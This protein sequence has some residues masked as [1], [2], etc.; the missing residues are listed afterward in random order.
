[1]FRSLPLVL[2]LCWC[3]AGRLSAQT[4]FACEGQFYLTLTDNGSTNLYLVEV[5]ALTGT[6]EF[7][8]I[9]WLGE[10]VNATGYRKT[11]NLIYGLQPLD[12][13]LFRIDALG[14]L[15]TLATLD[16]S[17]VNTYYAGDVTP[18]G[19]HLILI[20][21]TG[22]VQDGE[23]VELVTVELDQ[24]GY[25]FTSIPI[26]GPSVRMFDVAFDPLSG[27]LYG[28][29]SNNDRLVVLNPL[30]GVVTETFPANPTI[31]NTG[32]LF[33]NAF[34]ELFAYGSTGA[35]NEQRT[36]FQIFTQ[37]GSAIVLTEGPEAQGTDACSC[38]YTL[39]MT[40]KVDKSQTLTCSELIYTF[41]IAN[42][43]GT[44][45]TGVDFEDQ[46]PPGFTA[47]HIVRNPFNGTVESGPD[48]NFINIT[49]NTIPPGID[50]FVVRVT[51]GQVESGIYNNQAILRNLPLSLGQFR[52]SDNPATLIPEDSTSVE[53]VAVDFDTMRLQASVCKGDTTWVDVGQ[54]GESFLWQDGATTPLY[55]LTQA[56]SYWVEVTY[57]CDVG[58]V[59]YTVQENAV[60]LFFGESSF[61][62]LLGDSVQLQSNV[63]FDG[64]FLFYEWEDPLGN[65]LSCHTC[66]EPYAK[67][68]FDVVY[69]LTIQNDL[70]CA[71]TR[72]VEVLVDKTR[73]LY[74]PNAFSPNDDGINDL[75]FPLGRPDILVRNFQIFDR[76]GI[77]V[78]QQQNRFVNDPDAGWNGRL[79]GERLNPAIFVYLLEVEFLDGIREVYTGDVFLL[80]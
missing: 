34:G 39:E 69:Q 44:T 27:K 13:R 11:D 10:Q 41:T 22:G 29:D 79:R 64:D 24:P 6:V 74:L 59:L 45:Q 40:K 67:P 1:M 77:L 14:Q 30:T 48:T 20:G 43:S 28:Y 56:G 15:E 75:F 8:Q 32:S 21:S 50:S 31:N 19:Q 2:L 68:F 70:G 17:P 23:D 60:E 63:L 52:R 42:S 66:R 72:S 35:E 62:I 61:E 73:E 37:D 9:N 18:D 12:F 33:F 55:P 78:F 57:G 3:L 36:L 80:R 76:W 65:S 71:V 25:P 7:Q 4:P 49:N 46:L 54:F 47:T 5:S 51:V 38:P 26:T 58:V 53:V 16:L